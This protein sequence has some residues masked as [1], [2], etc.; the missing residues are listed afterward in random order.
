MGKL[1]N[2]MECSDG[3]TNGIIHI[4]F[5]EED[6][7]IVIETED[8]EIYITFTEMQ[9]LK[10]IY[11]LFFK[12]TFI[13]LEIGKFEYAHEFVIDSDGFKVGICLYATKQHITLF[14]KNEFINIDKNSFK[15]LIEKVQEEK[16]D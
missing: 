14:N 12:P 2:F 16:D 9:I 5:E 13:S 11:T 3:P 1:A 6:G 15:Y 10:N 7:G 8:K 4:F